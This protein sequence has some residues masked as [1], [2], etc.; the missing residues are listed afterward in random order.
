[1]IKKRFVPLFILVL[2]IVSFNVSAQ[3]QTNTA[4]LQKAGIETARKE[5]D[6][7]QQLLLVAK[8]KNWPLSMR[9]KNGGRALLVG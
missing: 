2:L 9:S 4:L 8:N 3:L 7:F 1:M 5:R 6:R